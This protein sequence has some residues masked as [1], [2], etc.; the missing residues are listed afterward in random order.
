[1][2]NQVEELFRQIEEDPDLSASLYDPVLFAQ[3]FLD[4]TPRW[5]QQKILRDPHNLK[6]ARWGRRN[7][8]TFSM[9]LHMIYYAITHPDSKQLIIGPLGIQVDTIFDELRKFIK[10]HPL[11]ELSMTRS[12]KTPQRIEFGN[13]ALI[14]GLSAGTSS[15]SGAKNVRGQGANWI[16]LDETD[17]LSEDDLNS[18]MGMQLE[19]FENIGVW[20]SSTPT[21]ARKMFWEWCTRSSCSWSITDREAY[22][23]AEKPEDV[24]NYV[25]RD[26]GNG[27]HEYHYP[28]WV[29]PNW[30]EK[31]EAKLRAMFS[32]QGYVHEVLAQFGD[33]TTGVFSKN[34]I[35][36][37]KFDY[38]Y[39]EM[40]KR[41]RVEGRIT[42]I[43]VDWDKYGAATQIVVSEY[44][45]EE[46]RVRVLERVEIP[47]TEFTFDNAVNRIV[48]L[49]EF[50]RPDNIYVDRGY[51]EYQVEVLKKKIG[52]D[53]VTGIAFQSKI[54]VQ[55]PTDN[56]V[57]KKETKTF[58]VNQATIMLERDQLMISKHDDMIY[59]Q[60]ERYQ[61]VKRSTTGKPIFTSENEH[62][63]DA[64]MLTILC[65][66]HEYPE[67]AK[68]LEK[69]RIAT[70]MGFVKKTLHS[71]EEKKIFGS[72][73][74]KRNK[75]EVDSGDSNYA[76]HMQ[77][78]VFH[79]KN[80]ATAKRSWGSRGRQRR[81]LGRRSF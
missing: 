49:H 43:G 2:A 70:T 11:L 47:S 75:N 57:D 26:G 55:D 72:E 31:M 34:K 56:T 15:G 62:A 19:D 16:Y 63:L 13:G 29:S 50:W 7:G 79:S 73:K 24:E 21:G 76:K 59:T 38:T 5:Y 23:E 37:S 77:S 65:Y 41:G 22:L 20:C 27:W 78:I 6:V 40:R 51:G 32:A 36:D 17:Y 68:I 28:S 45:E 33:E 53:I 74:S 42:A 8:K 81:T 9:I 30:S 61:V 44:D 4:V 54:Q 35:D 46:G 25:E 80:G 18:I 69:N 66:N 48:K 60:M 58:M 10:N 12:V 39:E 1:M 14:M 3:V 67:L 71:N 52:K 64:F